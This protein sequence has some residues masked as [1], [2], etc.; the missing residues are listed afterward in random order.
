MPV[1]EPA[2][3]YIKETKV[4][5]QSEWTYYKKQFSY[6]LSGGKEDNLGGVM[7]RTYVA[8]LR[9][10]QMT[11]SLMVGLRLLTTGQSISEAAMGFLLYHFAGQWVFGWP[12]D[13]ISGGG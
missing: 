8:R 7:W 10:I 3:K 5:S 13:V 2:E 4:N 11:F 6:F 1:Y 9:T 12:W